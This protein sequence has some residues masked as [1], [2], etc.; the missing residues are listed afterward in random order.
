MPTYHY[1]CEKC[2][3]EFEIEQR[4]SDSPRKRCPRCRGSLYR[5]IHPVGHILRG[6]GF[7]ATDYRSEDFKRKEREETAE[8]AG[9]KEGK[10]NKKEQ[11]ASQ[12]A[13]STGP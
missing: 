8:A 5:V 6:S 3:H 13:D 4:I 2:G 7:Y 11:P 9:P 12:D 1:A 10:E